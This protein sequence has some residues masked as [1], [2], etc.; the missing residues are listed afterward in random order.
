MRSVLLGIGVGV[1]LV[2]CGGSSEPAAGPPP[3]DPYTSRPD[4]TVV[5]GAG[6]GS[7]TVA[8][9]PS[10]DGCIYLPSGECVQPQKRCKPGE[11]AD[12]I[13][14]STGKVVE[15][16]CYPATESPT[17]IDGEG[18][19]ELGRNK[20]VVSVDG[21]DDGI[22]IAGDVSARGNNVTVYGQGSAV[23]IIGGDVNGDGN[24]FAIRGVTVKKD[25]HVNGNNATLVLCVVEGDV[26]IRGNN[27]VIAD[28][29]IGG[30]VE[31]YGNNGVLVANEVAGSIQ[32]FGTNT[33]CDAN[34]T[35]NDANGNKLLDANETG[36]P[37]ACEA[38]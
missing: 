23:S 12:V 5:V 27:A 2:C 14:D 11:R 6:A 15:V 35:W 18:N 8:A 16:V 9:T 28:C 24:N 1:V 31:I 20:G 17:P 7:G 19:I 29:T 13:I 3:G 38:K 4:T 34:V 22:D 25:V 26:I 33:A 30:K 36:A 21:V 10:G 37:L 32:V